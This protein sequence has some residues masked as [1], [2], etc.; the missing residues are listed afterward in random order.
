M[1]KQESGV[2][3]K[4]FW[5]RNSP[6]F[7]GFLFLFVLLGFISEFHF[8]GKILQWLPGSLAPQGA[9]PDYL[10]ARRWFVASQFI[11]ACGGLVAA[12]YVGEGKCGKGIGWMLGVISAVQLFILSFPTTYDQHWPVTICL[13]EYG[14]FVMADVFGWINIHHILKADPSKTDQQ[15]ACATHAYQFPLFFTDIPAGAVTLLLLLCFLTQ[16]SPSITFS[17]LTGASAAITVLNNFAY[18]AVQA[19]IRREQE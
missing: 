9:S 7:L 13:I 8:F 18:A 3:F 2:R 12:F 15:R 6:I 16:G 10:Y 11:N 1:A 5:K 14:V 17:F 19:W 4:T